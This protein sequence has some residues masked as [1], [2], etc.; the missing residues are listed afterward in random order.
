MENSDSLLA[1][2]QR[3]LFVCQQIA[4][5]Y[6]DCAYISD[7]I[8]DFKDPIQNRYR[9]IPPLGRIT[10]SPLFYSFDLKLKFFHFPLFFPL[11][12]NN[13]NAHQKSIILSSR[14]ISCCASIINYLNIQLYY[15]CLQAM[16]QKA[17]WDLLSDELAQVP[18]CYNQVRLKSGLPQGQA[19]F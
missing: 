17:F 19:H 1:L 8:A 14:F 4:F 15:S 10:Y 11:Q 16:M 6:F 5:C 2:V 13:I 9:A 7:A 3:T 18:P 12:N